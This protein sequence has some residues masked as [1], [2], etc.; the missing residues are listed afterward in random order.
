MKWPWCWDRLKAGRE[1]DDRG[2]DGWMASL[3]QWTRVWASSGSWWWTGKPGVLRSTVSQRVE[4][5][6]TTELI[7]INFTNIFIYTTFPL[8]INLLTYSFISWLL[9][10]M[11]RSSQPR[12][13]HRYPALQVDSLPSELPGKPNKQH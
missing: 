3:I 4:H 11:N 2:W 9:T 8:S 13:E 6:W 5:N 10:L 12:S 1:G 7:H